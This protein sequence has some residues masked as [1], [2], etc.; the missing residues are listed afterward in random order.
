MKKISLGKSL[1]IFF[2]QEN[3]SEKYYDNKMEELFELKMRNLTMCATH[4]FVGTI[5]KIELSLGQNY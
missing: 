2:Q 3:L 5:Q 4:I 1:K